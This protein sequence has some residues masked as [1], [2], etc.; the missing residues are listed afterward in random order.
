MYV[1]AMLTA[2]AVVATVIAVEQLLPYRYVYSL[3]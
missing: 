2:G 1:L 3:P